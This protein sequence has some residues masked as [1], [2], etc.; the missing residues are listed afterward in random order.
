[1][2]T[3]IACLFLFSLATFA[4]PSFHVPPPV[5]RVS[6]LTF[7]PIAIDESHPSHRRVGKLEFLAGYSIRSNDPRFGGLSAMH[8]DGGKLV[9]LSDAGSVFQFAVPSRGGNE[10]ADIRLLRDGP[11]PAEHKRNRDIESLAVAGGKAWLGFENRNAVWRYDLRTWRSEGGTTPR[12]MAGWPK[13]AGAEA[14]LRLA[15]GRFLVFSEGQEE[16]GG[17]TQ[18]LLFGS[19]PA[20]A[21]QTPVALR[22]RAAQGYKITDAAMLGDGRVLFLH[23]RLSWLGRFSAKLTIGRLPAL[24]HGAIVTGREVAAFEA[25]IAADNFEAL[26]IT[27]QNGRDTVWI[28]SDNNFSQLQRT[29]LLKFQLAD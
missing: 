22:Y 12:A 8:I 6:L 16:T 17:T 7:A 18:L 21:G 3:V 29:L 10:R 9:A 27:R 23:R 24:R 13:S 15:D 4:P 14:M 25:P 26:A 11:G 19:D 1:M 2:R 20:A 5:P 28:A